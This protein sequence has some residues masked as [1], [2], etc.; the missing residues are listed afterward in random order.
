MKQF[1]QKLALSILLLSSLSLAACG[2]GGG[3]G[4]AG[5]GDGGD[6]GGNTNQPPVAKAGPDL[7]VSR[8]F[9]ANL[10]AS[11][12]SDA[13]GDVLTYSWTQTAGPAVDGISGPFAPADREH[14]SARHHPAG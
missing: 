9:T 14:L 11:E 10:D 6:G 1:N 3:G 4:D 13:D 8:N 2:G 5:D 7:Q 12:S